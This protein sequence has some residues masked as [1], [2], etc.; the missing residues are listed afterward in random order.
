MNSDM[1]DKQL[2]ALAAEYGFKDFQ[3]NLFT[4]VAR[5]QDL[6]HISKKANSEIRSCYLIKD[7]QKLIINTC[8]RRYYSV[9]WI[10]IHTMTAEL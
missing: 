8:S 3:N 10:D 9:F 4:V 5:V 1:S 6:D 7:P 2:L